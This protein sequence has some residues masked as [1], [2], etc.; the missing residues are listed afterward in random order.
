MVEEVYVGEI[1][2]ERKG[3]CAQGQ[4]TNLRSFKNFVN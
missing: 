3:L 2:S 4:E 1:T